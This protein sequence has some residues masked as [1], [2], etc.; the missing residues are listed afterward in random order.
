MLD[1]TFE[2]KK[3]E[4]KDFTLIPEGIYEASI[5]DVNEKERRKY[6][7]T[8]T[9]QALNFQFEIE[10]G[11]Y[12][13]NYLWKMV[14][15]VYNEGFEGGQPSWLYQIFRACGALVVEP[16]AQ[17]I[18]GLIGKR[19]KIIV[20]HKESKDGNYYAIISD[21]LKSESSGEDL[22]DDIEEEEL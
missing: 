16:T 14:S 3:P 17:D 15:P 11:E 7:S 2:V 12:K 20:K 8:E 22:L 4:K 9:E 21:F 1:E 19:V 5:V 18:N 10:E 13:G 6:K